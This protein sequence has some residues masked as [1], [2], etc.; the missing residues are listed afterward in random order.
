MQNELETLKVALDL[1]IMKKVDAERTSSIAYSQ[2]GEQYTA[3]LVESDTNLMN[4]PS[5]HTA[6][7][8]SILSNDYRVNKV[9]TLAELPKKNEAASPIVLKILADYAARSK[10]TLEYSVIAP[11]GSTLFHVNDILTVFPFYRPDPIELERTSQKQTLNWKQAPKGADIPSIL[12]EYAIKGL[13]KNFPLYNF[14]S[15]YGTAVL[16]K[17]G[18]IYFGGQYSSPDKRLAL[19]SEMTVLLSA[20]MN[21]ERNITHLGLVSTKYTDEPCNMCGI[22][23]QFVSEMESRFGFKLTIMCFAKESETFS[24]HTTSDYLPSTWTSK[25]WKR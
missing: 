2:S 20:L 13:A 22:C 19:H 11:D 6:L 16:T 23:R 10:T 1:S 15:G 25:K 14:A 24:E 18:K 4:I 8:F 7:A 21:N 12:K 17:S 5:E 3:G 9:V